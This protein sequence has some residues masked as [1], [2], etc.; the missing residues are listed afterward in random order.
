MQSSVLAYS[1]PLAG[2]LDPLMS[3]C[4]S[5]ARICPLSHRQPGHP[6]QAGAQGGKMSQRHTVTQRP[7]YHRLLCWEERPLPQQGAVLPRSLPPRPALC[8]IAVLRS[9]R[10]VIH[11]ASASQYREAALKYVLCGRLVGWGL[12]HCLMG[13]GELSREEMGGTDR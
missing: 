3:T 12:S 1:S 9:G 8:F 4:L 6:P 11:G 10:N 2:A 7:L 13:W 5:N